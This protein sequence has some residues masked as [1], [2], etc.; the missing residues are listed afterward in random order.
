MSK[1]SLPGSFLGDFRGCRDSK[2][3]QKEI[4]LHCIRK[5]SK[6]RILWKEFKNWNE[7]GVLRA[8][9]YLLRLKLMLQL[10]LHREGK[11]IRVWTKPENKNEIGEQEMEI[12]IV[13]RLSLAPTSFSRL[14]GSRHCWFDLMLEL[15]PVG[16]ET[17]DWFCSYS[18]LRTCIS[19]LS[20]FSFGSNYLNPDPACGRYLSIS[21]YWV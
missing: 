4:K 10:Q 14:F 2:S 19:P 12:E 18:K 13:T 16:V 15:L 1:N 3:N 11:K 21:T 20:L 5:T 9:P 6:R 7:R 17:V 8:L